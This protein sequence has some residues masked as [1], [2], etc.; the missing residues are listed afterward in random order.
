MKAT[1]AAV[2]LFGFIGRCQNLPI[3]A[4]NSDYPSNPPTGSPDAGSPSSDA[5]S[6]NTDAGSGDAGST[7]LDAAVPSTDAGSPDAG[8]PSL[9]AGLPNTDAGSS[10]Q[11]D[12]A[13]ADGGAPAADVCQGPPGLFADD[14]CQEL[15]EGLTPYTPNYELWADGATKERLIYLPPGTQIDTRNPDRWNFP[16]G[17]RIYK[18]FRANGLKLETRMIEKRAPAA[19]AE[20]WQF[21]AWLWSADQRHVAAAAVAGENNVLGTNHDV[22]SQAQCQTCHAQ[23]GLDAVNGFGAVQLNHDK[24]GWTLRKLIAEQKLLNGAGGE[25]NVDERRA[26]LPGDAKAQAALGYLHGNCAHCHGG[27]APRAS[28]TLTALVGMADVSNAPA[29]A[30][31]CSCLKRWTGRLARDGSALS[32]RITP[33]SAAHSGIVGRMSVRKAGEQMPPVGTELVDDR[34]VSAVSAWID[35]LDPYQC[36]EA[37]P[38]CPLPMA[39][40]GAGGAAA[41]G[42]AG[43]LTAGGPAALGGAGAGAS[44]PAAGAPAVA[45]SA[46]P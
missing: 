19:A 33:G 28:L 16:V 39:A 7:G 6:P 3:P 26:S 27:P 13:A 36:A 24:A 44:V 46:A 40:A 2:L 20:S 25:L 4:G 11:P 35:A 38:V 45:G 18:T 31:S 42:G 41:V 14:N 5:G 37:E 21:S 30:S 43:A 22:P 10:T 32:L 8:N 1:L 17:T 12:A 23:P 29:Y 34:G 15:S 9:D